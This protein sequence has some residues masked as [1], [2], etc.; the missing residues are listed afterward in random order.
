MVM[1]LYIFVD[2]QLHE[3]SNS[4]SKHESCK[5]SLSTTVCI[6]LYWILK[7]RNTK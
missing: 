7:T 4:Y 1:T 3:W 2:D 5:P 6:V